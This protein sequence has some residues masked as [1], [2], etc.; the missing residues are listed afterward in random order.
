[1]PEPELLS[2]EVLYSEPFTYSDGNLATVASSAWAEPLWTGETG[3][4]IVS[5]A[6]A[7]RSAAG[8]GG[9]YTLDADLG[10][11]GDYAVTV[12]T[13][14]D[15]D[16]QFI[17][18]IAAS[19]QGESVSGRTNTN[20]PTS[21][22]LSLN[23]LSGTDRIRLF[24]W[25]NGSSTTVIDVNREVAAGDVLVIR[26][27]G[28]D[29]SLWHL[30]GGVVGDAVQ[31]GSTWT[32]SS[33]LSASGRVGFETNTGNVR[34]DNLAHY[35]LAP[36]P[37]PLTPELTAGPTP[38]RISA[39]AGRDEAAFEFSVDGPAEAWELRAVSDG[40]DPRDEGDPLVLSGG[41]VAE[42]ESEVVTYADLAAAGIAG[43]DGP[44]LLKLYALNDAGWS[45]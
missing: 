32:D 31:V 28:A 16:R 3:L 26:R 45:A 29:L 21:Y 17:W 5:N 6:L 13:K 43:A 8:W 36:P 27:E 9:A 24:K 42:S 34:F 7:G 33:P 44:K 30:P 22:A 12:A 18:H 23:V 19:Y 41:A 35:S 38:A 2:G 14:P 37:E 39:V 40:A 4:R 15:T 10:D 11:D 20:G 25:A 1:M